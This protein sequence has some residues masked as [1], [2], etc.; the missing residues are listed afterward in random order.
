MFIRVDLPAPFSPI[1]PCT[2]PR[3]TERET[4]R[5]A[6][7]APKRLSI[8]RS[9]SAGPEAAPGA[10]GAR[11][12]GSTALRRL[13]FGNTHLARDDVGLR[14][15]EA[16]LHFRGDQLAIGVVERVADAVL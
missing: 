2:D 9:S 15:V 6:C 12:C 11:L 1:S 10:W 13:V 14:L 4:A 3:A 7:T 5:L 8:E 16:R